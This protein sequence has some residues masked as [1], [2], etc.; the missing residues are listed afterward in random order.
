MKV[1]K[2]TTIGMLGAFAILS[3]SNG[4]AIAHSSNKTNLYYYTTSKGNKLALEAAKAWATEDCKGK[5]ITR[6]LKPNK[7]GGRVDFICLDGHGSTGSIKFQR[8]SGGRMLPD[9]FIYAG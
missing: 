8:I 4:A 7:N 2:L 6:A 5:V 9:K 1:R 3:L